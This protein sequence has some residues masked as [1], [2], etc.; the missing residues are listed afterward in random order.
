MNNP[1][2]K[3]LGLLLL[4]ALQIFGLQ[5]L[6]KVTSSDT[7]DSEYKSDS[8]NNNNDGNSIVRGSPLVSVIIPSYNRFKYLKNTIES[9]H[10]Q[11]YENVEII[12]INDGSSQAEYKTFDYSIYGDKFQIIHLKENSHKENSRSPAAFGRNIGIKYASGNST[13]K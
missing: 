10:S 7:R 6:K 13:F 9:V 11:N 4:I 3:V 5:I 1:F 12:V 2:K 8:V